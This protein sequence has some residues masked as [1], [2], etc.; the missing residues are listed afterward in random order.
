MKRATNPRG[1]VASY[2]M[3]WTAKPLAYFSGSAGSKVTP[4]KSVSF[5]MSS[6]GAST[7]ISFATSR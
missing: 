1:I 2:A 4:S 5:F 6:R 3:L 7:P